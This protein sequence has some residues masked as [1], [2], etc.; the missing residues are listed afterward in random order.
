MSK[1]KAKKN[2]KS[3]KIAKSTWISLGV[4]SAIAIACGVPLGFKLHAMLLADEVDDSNVDTNAFTVNYDS[5]L[6]KYRRAKATGGSYDDTFTAPDL[7]NV[8]IAL[9]ISNSTWFAQCSGQAVVPAVN[10]V[11]QIRSTKIRASDSYF[12]ESNSQSSVVAL[13]DRAYSSGGTTKAYHGTIGSSVEE[14]VY[15]AKNVTSYTDKEY[16]DYMGHYVSAPVIYLICKGTT[17]TTGTPDSGK[18]TAI[19][20]HSDGTYTVDLELDKNTACF[21]YKTQMVAISNLATRPTF[22]F[23]HLTF[24]LDK[25]L[26]PLSYVAYEKYY[27]KTKAGVGSEIVATLKTEFK[28]GGAYAIPDL[29]IPISYTVK[30]S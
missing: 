14:G 18:A 19:A 8:S 9:L 22:Y 1:A 5:L 4:A 13:A 28:M 29:N 27:A 7:A 16:K 15:E 3:K 12:E 6:T 23:C 11:Q 2:Q 24:E 26:N 30:A 20:H 17:V 21:N 25:D 10:V